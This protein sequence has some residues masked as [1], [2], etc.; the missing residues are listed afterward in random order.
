M[1]E[2][3]FTSRRKEINTAKEGDFKA[4][5]VAWGVWIAEYKLRDIGRHVVLPLDET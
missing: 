2:T 1:S 5:D 4:N 3:S